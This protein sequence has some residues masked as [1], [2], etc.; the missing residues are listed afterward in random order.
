VKGISVIIPAY[1]SA[2]SVGDAIDSV[3][4]Q[5]CPVSETIVVDD[6]S[7]DHTAEVAARFDEVCYV[8]EE[9]QG[10]AVA[11]NT[12][13]RHA[14]GDY[15]VFLDAD[16][17]L[18][19]GALAAG[20]RCL[21]RHPGCAFASGH[22]RFITREGSFLDEHRPGRI[23]EDPYRA[24][25]RKNHVGMHAT[26]MYRRLQLERIGGFDPA[27]RACEDYD[28][29]LRI[30]REFPVCRH[31]EVVAEYRKH[32]ANMSSD[33]RLMLEA[34]LAVLAKQAGYADA[35]PERRTAL[36]AGARLWKE[37][38]AEQ[39]VGQLRADPGRLRDPSEAM[40]GLM[41]I[42]RYG[43]RWAVRRTIAQARSAGW[44]LKHILAR[45]RV[46]RVNLGDFRRVTPISDVFGY[47]RGR[48][49]DRYYIENF[50]A[51]H[52]ADVRGRV[53]EIGDDAYTRR[54]GGEHVTRSDV[55]HVEAGNPRATFVGDLTTAE[56][57]PSD[58][59]D[60]IVLTQTLHLI[61]DVR[62][63]LAT[64]HRVLTP[65]GVLL[66]TFPGISRIDRGEW[67]G[68]WCWSFTLHSATCLFEEVFPPSALTMETHGNVLAAVSFLHGLAVEDLRPEELDHRDPNYQVVI[69][70][71]AVKPDH[72][73][74]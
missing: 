58:A 73:G 71:R 72:H 39:L 46:G 30:A 26:V 12:G 43:P 57:L 24:F 6:G 10:L 69:A 7:D 19:P 61:Y 15:L 31:G 8:R 55:L 50:L 67:G 22:F 27:L 44:R 5:T 66:A 48:P 11:R 37:Y 74:N 16:D 40:R 62:A 60:C 17:R 2:R 47:D 25:L 68:A 14:R 49:V 42:L 36:R 18:L 34:A 35:D 63:A 28:V 1:N 59:F 56:H 29:Y 33:T 52:A 70:V 20:L 4:S 38:Y 45:P 3:L 65:G 54:F 41:A 32:G 23:D 51:A 9:N 21:E 13:M 53:L 64:L